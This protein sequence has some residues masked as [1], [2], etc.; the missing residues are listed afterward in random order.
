VSVYRIISAERAS[1]PVSVMCEVLGV[2]RSGFHGWERR[3]PSDRALSDA[4]LTSRITDIHKQ[5]RGV[6]GSR[7]VQ[8]ELR[9]GQGIWVS[10][11]RVRR[12]MRQAGLG[13]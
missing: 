4:W 13:W 9:L 1:F 2:S 11:K 10:R 6:Y 7:R 12:L 5:A 8:A 3:A